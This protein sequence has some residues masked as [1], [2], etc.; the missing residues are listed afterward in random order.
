VLWPA[1]VLETVIAAAIE[2]HSYGLAR[3][4]A[5][6]RYAGPRREDVV[7]M[8]RSARARGR[9]A[10]QSG[11]RRVPVDILED[12]ELTRWLSVTPDTQP[13]SNWQAT[14]TAARR[15]TLTTPTTLVYNRQAQPYTADGIGQELAK[16]IQALHT[17]G[18][19]DRDAYNFHGLRH[20]R[21]VE[22]ALA[23]C[24]DAEGAAQMGHASPS[25]FAQYRRQADR[26]RMA[27]NAADKVIQLRTRDAA[28]A[29]GTAGATESATEVQRPANLPGAR[30]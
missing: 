22:L 25:S 16:L 4:V 7:R 17:A 5:I 29:S 11:K 18:R 30:R 15:R 24:T 26:I 13:L 8:G 23:G 12:P 28:N 27:D 6:A 1:D 20:T 19:I 9:I 10:F 3:A 2:Q 21:G 14:R